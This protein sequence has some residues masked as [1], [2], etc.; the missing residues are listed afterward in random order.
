MPFDFEPFD[1]ANLEEFEEFW[2]DCVVRLTV[3]RLMHS[4]NLSF[5]DNLLSAFFSLNSYLNLLYLV[6]EDLAEFLLVNSKYLSITPATP[7]IPVDFQ[8]TK[9]SPALYYISFLSLCPYSRQHM[10][11][12]SQITYSTLTQIFNQNDQPCL[13]AWYLYLS[14]IVLPMLFSSLLWFY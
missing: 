6:L 14:L 9:P 5:F 13:W 4:R 7:S 12:H 2:L 8:T 1:W 11:Y 10:A 3:F